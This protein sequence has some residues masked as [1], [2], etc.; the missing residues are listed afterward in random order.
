MNKKQAI[1]WYEKLPDD[2]RMKLQKDFSDK[3]DNLG[4]R[5]TKFYKWLTTFTKTK[6]KQICG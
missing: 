3:Y 5:E 6:Q 4:S 2:V 1:E